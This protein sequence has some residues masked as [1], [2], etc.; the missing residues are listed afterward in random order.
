MTDSEKIIIHNLNLINKMKKKYDWIEFF[1]NDFDYVKLNNKWGLINKKGK[2]ILE[3]KY[4]YVY[5]LNEAFEKYLDF[6]NKNMKNN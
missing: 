4:D 3:C 1:N 5:E 2:E 6:N